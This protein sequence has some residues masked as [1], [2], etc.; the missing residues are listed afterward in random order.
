MPQKTADL[1]FR[2]DRIKALFVGPSGTGKSI[3]AAT[4][5]RP[6]YIMDI[7]SRI[8]SIRN[9]FHHRHDFLDGIY[10]DTFGSFSE[11]VKAFEILER[12]AATNN[13]RYKTIFLD[14]L[15]SL[16]QSTIRHGLV[17]KA[18]GVTS[19]LSGGKGF[20]IAGVSI[21]MFDEWNMEA[22]VFRD[23]MYAATHVF[24]CNVI[25][26]AHQ[27]HTDE[28]ET[29]IDSRGK[30]VQENVVK[31]HIFTGAKKA[32]AALPTDFDEIYYFK[33]NG[34]KH[35]VHTQGV[36]EFDHVKTALPLPQQMDITMKPNARLDNGKLKPIDAYNGSLY[37]KILKECK[38]GGMEIAE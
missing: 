32:A 30:T 23:V 16:S 25:L 4:F 5:P 3:A 37:H 13:L 28:V 36:R 1:K 26:S 35:L 19:L 7:D 34:A 2:L 21:P 24:K 18:G 27:Y 22:T 15:T 17:E 9:F 29:T 8:R 31:Y 6:L 12:D 33:R 14:S 20:K 10:H 38:S 11:F